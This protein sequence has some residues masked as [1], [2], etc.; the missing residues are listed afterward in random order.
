MD[1]LGHRIDD[2]GLHAD[3]DKLTRVLE[4][5]SPRSHNEVQRL[6]G[7]IQYLANFLPDIAHFTS[8]LESICRNGLS[9]F[10]RPFHQLCLERIKSIIRKTPILKPID[11]NNPD[12]IWVINDVSVVGVGAVYGQGKD[13]KT[14]RPAGFMSKKFMSAQR[15]YKTYEQEALAVIESLMKWEDKL[16]GR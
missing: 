4:W 15:S 13:W 12:P 10:W 5:R 9:F 14:C 8:P 6:L 7:L 1:C 16:L 11:V 2:R 3:D